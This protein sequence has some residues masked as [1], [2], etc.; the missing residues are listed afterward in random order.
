MRETHS[1]LN[2][3]KY[4]KSFH[5]NFHIWFF[6]LHVFKFFCQSFSLRFQILV[7]VTRKGKNWYKEITNKYIHTHTH[8]SAT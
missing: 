4:D 3:R 6:F 2:R 7:S 8:V 5:P 1:N